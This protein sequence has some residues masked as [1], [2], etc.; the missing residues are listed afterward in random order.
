MR[1]F[2]C[3]GAI[4]AVFCWSVVPAVAASFHPTVIRP[5]ASITTRS[6]ASQ[7]S[8][9]ANARASYATGNP[10]VSPRVP[11]GRHGAQI[12][13]SANANAAAIRSSHQSVT[14]P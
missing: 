3:I 8:A 6:S 13:A 12:N 5:L 11:A 1:R 9:R 14:A 2:S 4:L 7:M 10:Y